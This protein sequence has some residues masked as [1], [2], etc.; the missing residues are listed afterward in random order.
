MSV[1][2]EPNDPSKRGRVE[3]DAIKPSFDGCNPPVKNITHP[4]RYYEFTRDEIKALEEC[5][6]ESFYRR[7]LPF[8]TLFATATYAAVKYG[9]FKPNPRFGAIPKIS[10]A[11]LVGYFVGKL[12]YQEACAEKLMA[13]PG[14]Y[15][16]QLL[17]EKKEGRMGGGGNIQSTPSMFGAG[18][19][20]IYSDAGPGSSLDLDTD[21]PVFSDDSYRPDNEGG[22]FP[23]LGPDRKGPALS[24]DDLRRRNRGEYTEARQDPY[25]VDPNTVPP[26]TR[27]PP[28]VDAPPPAPRHTNQYGDV[29]D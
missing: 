29:M 7:C 6:K 1:K 13:L 9:Y 24:Y 25:R 11:V 12:S 10:F 20:D 2:N 21:R 15:I 14:S 4:L 26:I 5:D 28:A 16:G 19:N 18:P 23:S 22:G 27:A 8:S 17:R 3:C